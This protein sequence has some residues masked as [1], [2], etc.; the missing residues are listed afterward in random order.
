M[1][2]ILP[3]AGYATRMYP[4]TENIPKALLKINNKPILDYI[5]QQLTQLDNIS[6]IILITNNK[7]H[8]HFKDW[9]KDK[10]ITIINN[11]TNNNN[12]RLG[13][14]K[15]IQLGLNKCHEDFLIINA[16]NLFDL[17][18]KQANQK[19]KQLNKPLITTY[20]VKN[21]EIAKQMGTLTTNKE[22]RVMDFKEKDPYVTSTLCSIGIYFFPKQTKELINNYLNQNNSPDCS[23]NF[24]E[25]LYKEQPTYI[26]NFQKGIWYDIG[27][28]ECYEAAKNSPSFR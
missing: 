10:K 3:A 13:T 15:D 25:W 9:A 28:I 26:H 2:V 14:I 11:N 22:G 7:H 19:F 21:I 1:K 27:S 17:D 4:L 6:E 8:Q 23:G 20:D 5:L 24:I 12:E 16:D 18:L